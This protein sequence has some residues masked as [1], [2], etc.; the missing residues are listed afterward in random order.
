VGA[1]KLQFDSVSGGRPSDGIAAQIRAHLATGALKVGDK[2]P[3]ERDLETQVGVS[4]NSIRQALKSLADMGLL[5]IR[6]GATGGAFVCGGSN[7][8]TN[9][10]S[11][12]FHLGTVRPQDLTEVRVILGAE[13]ARLATLR[14]DDSEIDVLEA[15]VVASEAAARAGQVDHRTELNFEFHHILARMTH[16]PLLVTL[17]EAVTAVTR[18]Y[19]Q[20]M[21]P[22]T[23][24]SVMPLRR[25]M[26][27][28][29]REHDAEGAAAE[30]REH[31]LRVERHYL[32][33]AVALPRGDGRG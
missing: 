11:D 10:F 8:V 31:L 12:Q 20:D 4:R 25:R 9:I 13:V 5:E 27:A 28:H 23:N 6:K 21:K 32:R 3:S 18:A 26:L 17:T 19:G 14:A 1:H 30:M 24:R 33:H 22:M 29:L 15:N 2:L 7:G 16:N